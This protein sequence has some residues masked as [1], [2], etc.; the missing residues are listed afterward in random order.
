MG[1]GFAA[2]SCVSCWFVS[3]FASAVITQV[4]QLTAFLYMILEEID[5]V[6][7]FAELSTVTSQVY[8]F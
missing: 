4:T 1:L 3:G 7:D 5:Q 2:I 8:W 6:T